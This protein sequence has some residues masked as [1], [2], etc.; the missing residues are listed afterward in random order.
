[1]A[2]PDG[3][4]SSM[5]EALQQPSEV[6]QGPVDVDQSVRHRDLGLGGRWYEGILPGRG[7]P[8]PWTCPECQAKHVGF[9]EDGCTSCGAGK[10][11][12][13]GRPAPALDV[14]CRACRG[15][16]TISVRCKQCRGTGEV[17]IS[18]GADTC[19]DCGGAG[20]L[21]IDCVRCARTPGFDPEPQPAA[22][23]ALTPAERGYVEE[24]IRALKRARNTMPD[25]N[26]VGMA[27]I[28]REAAPA[29]ALPKLEEETRP[30]D[31]VTIKPRFFLLAFFPGGEPAFVE[32]A[33]SPR[34]RQIIQQHG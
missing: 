28:L 25:D 7:R 1:M 30:L 33:D 18:G 31:M 34:V 22:R 29:R 9:V 27:N 23:D 19:L 13:Q 17:D 10:D 6:A 8:Y 24:S 26:S 12:R 20:T 15:E 5:T 3:T 16:K 32:I 2:N 11:A 14:I 21:T 4:P